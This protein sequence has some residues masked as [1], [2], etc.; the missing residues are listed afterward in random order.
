MQAAPIGDGVLWAEIIATYTEHAV[1]LRYQGIPIN[2]PDWTN[3][4]AQTTFA[5]TLQID[6]D[7]I[8]PC[9]EEFSKRRS[10]HET[11]PF[12]EKN[13]SSPV[14]GACAYMIDKIIHSIPH[15]VDFCCDNLFVRG[16]GQPQ[17]ADTYVV[18]GEKMLAPSHM[19]SG[20]W[21]EL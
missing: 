12:G 18:R 11:K 9:T 7:I 6:A 19:V 5:A 21:K 3:T 14:A 10:L 1:A 20:A 16:I 17:R 13:E 15:T 4:C 8:P 2:I